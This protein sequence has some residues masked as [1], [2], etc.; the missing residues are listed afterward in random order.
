[1]GQVLA[2]CPAQP[3]PAGGAPPAPAP[4]SAAAQHPR[5]PPRRRPRGWTRASPPARRPRPPG[6]APTCV[7]STRN[8]RGIKIATA[9]ATAG[10][11]SEDASVPVVPRRLFSLPRRAGQCPAR[12]RPESRASASNAFRG[13]RPALRRDTWA[14]PTGEPASGPGA[15][16]PGA[17]RGRPAE[18]DPRWPLPTRTASTRPP[19]GGPGQRPRRGPLRPTTLPGPATR[20]GQPGVAPHPV[21]SASVVPACHPSVWGAQCPPRLR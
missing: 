18:G 7:V 14:E 2:T 11:A 3:L 17:G 1:M 20:A 4:A 15:A 9:M 5:H 6:T 8:M 21:R 12:G 10:C 19:R 13:F 16:A